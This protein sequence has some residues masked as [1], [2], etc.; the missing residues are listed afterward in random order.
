[1]ENGTWLSRTCFFISEET[2]N[3]SVPKAR[4]MGSREI[5][6]LLDVWDSA[7]K[8][9]LASSP[10]EGGIIQ[11]LVQK[12]VKLKGHLYKSWH[13]FLSSPEVDLQKGKH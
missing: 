2:A 11:V 13:K 8:D 6:W 1:M 3:N 10:S 7:V 4:C 5:S 9:L 12:N